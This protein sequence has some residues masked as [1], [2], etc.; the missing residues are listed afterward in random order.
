MRVTPFIVSKIFIGWILLICIVL[1]VLLCNIP[2]EYK[3]FYRFGPHKDLRILGIQIDNG[4]KYFGV[5]LYSFINSVFRAAFHNYLNPWM[6]N[7]VQD[8]S[9]PKQH[10]DR[11]SVYEIASVCV[12]YQWTDWLL[13]MNIL[14]AQIDMMIIEVSADLMMSYVTTYYYLGTPSREFTPLRTI[15]F[16]QSAAR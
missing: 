2:S 11:Y 5:F 3:T 8:E 13:Y 15:S 7:N 10:L 4:W 12:I 6:I 14:L 16:E 9:R 1:T